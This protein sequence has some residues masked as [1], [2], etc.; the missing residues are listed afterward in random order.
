[1]VRG[2]GIGRESC[3]D[4]VGVRTKIQTLI[5]TVGDAV[6]GGVLWRWERGEIIC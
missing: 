3:L 4:V 6:A 5:L 2:V 1:M